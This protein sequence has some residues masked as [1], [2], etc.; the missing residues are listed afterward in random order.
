MEEDACTKLAAQ[1]R[2]TKNTLAEET[3]Q[4]RTET[5]QHYK[6]ESLHSTKKKAH[7]IGQKYSPVPPP[8][9][10]PTTTISLLFILIPQLLLHHHHHLHF[11]PLLIPLPFTTHHYH[12]SF[13]FILLLSPSPPA[14]G[15]FFPLFASP[16][17]SFTGKSHLFSL[18]SPLL[19][20]SS[21]FLSS[22]S[23]FSFWHTL[24]L[25]PPAPCPPSTP[26]LY[27]PPKLANP[28]A[29]KNPSRPN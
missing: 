22:S 23:S 29:V 28:R 10:T 7:S 2:S 5:P 15:L 1:E 20:S 17:S 14:T 11:F 16:S 27:Y 8:L 26:S 9:S 18:S 4:Y 25:V 13:P 12:L 24:G 6:T 21:S 3:L 19:S